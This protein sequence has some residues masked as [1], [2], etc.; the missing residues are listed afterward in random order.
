MNCLGV[1]LPFFL[2]WV[3]TF[4]CFAFLIA[5]LLQKS[6]NVIPTLAPTTPHVPTSSA[7]SCAPVNLVTLG[8]SAALMLMTVKI[9]HVSTMAHVKTWSTTSP[10]HAHS[11][12]KVSTATRIL[13]SVL[14]R[15]VLTMPRA[16]IFLVVINA[17]VSLVT[18]ESCVIRTLMNA[19]CVHVKMELLAET[20]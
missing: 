18:P 5:Y 14:L 4:D 11:V 19:Y 20:K 13:T 2:I 16:K 7:I 1:F 8:N 6:T 17:N 15:P 10:A 12:T 3:C 9:N